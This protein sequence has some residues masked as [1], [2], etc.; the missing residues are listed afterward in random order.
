MACALK[1]D[2]LSNPGRD[3]ERGREGQQV[4]R[5]ASAMQRDAERLAASIQQIGK[6]ETGQLHIGA[7]M[8]FCRLTQNTP[9]KPGCADCVWRGPAAG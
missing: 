4:Y 8:A 2:N 7:S 9:R 3:R 6:R 5:V 1:Q